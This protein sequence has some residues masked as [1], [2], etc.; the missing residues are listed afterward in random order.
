MPK[1]ITI[2]K[3]GIYKFNNLNY[4][5]IGCGTKDRSFV[6][7]LEIVNCSIDHVELFPGDVLVYNNKKYNFTEKGEIVEKSL[8][9]CDTSY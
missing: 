9:E 2:E 4:M 3:F 8:L 5:V 6:K 1:E 7:V